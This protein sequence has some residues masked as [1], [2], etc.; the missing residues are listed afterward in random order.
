[1]SFQANR[2]GPAPSAI[3]EHANERVVVP[4]NQLQI[5]YD[6]S[7]GIHAAYINTTTGADNAHVNFTS[8]G[9]YG[10]G[11]NRHAMGV[12]INASYRE[13]QASGQNPEYTVFT[14]QGVV[15][16]RRQI[17]VPSP[18]PGL[19]PL[20]GGFFFGTL[21]DNNPQRYVPSQTQMFPNYLPLQSSNTTQSDEEVFGDYEQLSWSINGSFILRQ[22]PLLDQY[23]YI[24]GFV[25]GRQTN[26]TGQ[27]TPYWYG[28][29]S[30]AA[31]R[32]PYPTF[33]SE[34]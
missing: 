4:F 12:A 15:H 29:I 8:N 10:S 23:P 5:D 25:H 21:V 18:R 22:Y 33:Q 20:M 9:D 2:I 16:A 30:C 28:T 3:F 11:A 13:N 24:F 32:L 1:M 34:G 6:N 14:Y 26:T 19:F 17:P 7:D 31:H 27:T